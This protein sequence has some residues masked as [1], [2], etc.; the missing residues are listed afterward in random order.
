MREDC[1]AIFLIGVRI[2][3]IKARLYRRVEGQSIGS[4]LHNSNTHDGEQ[5]RGIKRPSKGQVLVEIVAD[6]DIFLWLSKELCGE[7]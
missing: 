2:D 7:L 3:V 5:E 6:R 1:L 4:S